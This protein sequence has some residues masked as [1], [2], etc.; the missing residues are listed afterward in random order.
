[1]II[2]PIVVLLISALVTWLI[3]KRHNRIQWLVSSA[4]GFLAWVVV[5]FVD[6]ESADVLDLSFWQPA[7]LFQSPISLSIDALIWPLMYAAVTVLLAVIFT[8][9]T[10]PI[11]QHARVRSFWFLYTALA[12]IALMSAN[13]LTISVA[14]AMMDFGT[15]LFLLGISKDHD[16]RRVIFLRTSVN[17]LSVLLVLSAAMLSGI[18]GIV[19]LDLTSTSALG[20]LLLALAASF[21]L[22]LLP[23]HFALPTID[24]ER[25]GVGT[26]LRLFPPVVAMALLARVYAAGLPGGLRVAFFIAGSLGGVLGG[27]RW[28]FQE[29]P[30]RGRP[31]FVLSLASLGL[32][33]ATLSADGAQVIISSALLLLLVG[34]VIS[35]FANHTPSNRVIPVLASLMLLGFPFTPGGFISAAVAEPEVFFNSPIFAGITVLTAGLVALG[36]FHLFYAEEETW[37][38]SES[39]GRV[40]FNVG[41]VLPLLAAIGIGVWRLNANLLY[42]VSFFIAASGAGGLLFLVFRRITLDQVD[43][44]RSVFRF[45]EPENLYDSLWGVFQR[46][47]MSTRKLGDLYEGISGMLWLF[48]L[49]I[50]LLFIIR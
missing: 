1:M 36:T 38:I 7:D 8:S 14:W 9:A 42:S 20:I 5:L 19:A 15:M 31:F 33:A 50:Y 21:R 25:R 23:L 24:P 18:E 12:M 32:I 27:L 16:E 48:V 49:V 43:Q 4:L 30:V 28:V 13:L 26:L 6:V 17:A 10:R 35:L 2:I 29:E 3:R 11:A 47:L 45:L 34:A 46:I 22:G 41:L 37:P 44:I 39:L 40:M